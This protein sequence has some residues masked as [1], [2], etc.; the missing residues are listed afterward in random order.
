[1]K[2]FLVLLVEIC[3]TRML[4]FTKLNEDSFVCGVSTSGTEAK[5]ALL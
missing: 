5:A 4:S 1:M 2:F 3:S